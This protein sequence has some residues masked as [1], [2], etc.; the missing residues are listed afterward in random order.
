[1][2]IDQAG[3]PGLVQ[4]GLVLSQE[5]A[6]QVEAATTPGRRDRDLVL[7]D[8]QQ[9]VLDAVSEGHNVIVDA[10][11]GSGKAL[12]DQARVPTPGGWRRV[13]EIG[14]GDQLYNRH[15]DPVTVLGVYPQGL[16]QA[17]RVTLA[18]GRQVVCSGD[19]NWGVYRRSGRFQQ[20]ETLTTRQMVDSGL[21]P[22]L[23]G[24]SA[25]VSEFE[26]PTHAA[27]KR[28]AR[29][30]AVD[31]YVVGAFAGGGCGSEPGLS[32]SSQTP[33]VAQ[34][35]ARI[36]GL[37]TR[38]LLE[39]DRTWVFYRDDG[40]RS[41]GVLRDEVLQ[42]VPEICALPGARRL[43]E[44]YLLGS[45]EQRRALLQGLMDTRGTLTRTGTGYTACFST[46][47]AALAEQ[48]QDLLGSLGYVVSTTI[49]DGG[50][51]RL[52]W[53]DPGHD[54]A[55][56]AI[57]TIEDLGYRTEMTCF[58]VDDAESLFLTDDYVVTHNTATIQKLCAQASARGRRVL[59]LTYSRLLKVDAQAR[60]GGAR[61]QNYHGVVYP[62]LLAHGIEAGISESIRAFNANFD[63]IR[64]GF[65]A[66]DLLVIDEYQDINTEYARLIENI[67]SVNPGMQIVMVGDAD[68]KVQANTT[69]DAPAFARTFAGAQAKILP[70]TKTF[71]L[72]PELAGVLSKAWNKPIEG[73][74][75][76]QV[77]ELMDHEDAIELICATEPGDLLCL[78]KRNGAM[79]H[80]LNEVEKRAPA[81]Y[82]KDTVFASIKDGDNGVNPDETAAV[83]TTYDASKGM[84]RPVCVVFDYSEKTWDMRGGFAG[85]DH[86]VLRNVFLVAASRGKARVVFV[87][88]GAMKKMEEPRAGTAIGMIPVER[89]I[90]LPAKRIP[91][92]SR[93]FSPSSCFDFTY[94]ENVTACLDLITRRRL[95]T[96]TEKIIDI[97]RSDGFID[98]SPVIGV[99]QEALFFADFDAAATMRMMATVDESF[100]AE[101]LLSNLD[102]DPWNDSLVLAAVG[103]EQLRYYDQVTAEVASDEARALMDR[104]GEHLDRDA[105]AQVRL[106]L[107]GSAHGGR[108]GAS[109]PISFSGFADAMYR[110]QLFE[111]KFVSALSPEMFLQAALY[112]VMARVSGQD[113][114]QAV[115]WNT[116]TGERWAVDVEDAE[117][118]LH[119]VVRCVTKQ[120]YTRFSFEVLDQE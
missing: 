32:I 49:G 101:A 45:V 118:F 90:D 10:V 119:A 12:P 69:L 17:Y 6:E 91:R 106:S 8:E 14:V 41:G 53:A 116:R 82:N 3:G 46:V 84:E 105:P 37:G 73:M 28:P 100:H 114:H 22:G 102:G 1:M 76:E 81:R 88:S 67:R 25:P 13:G 31:P 36:L 92:Y 59:Y 72:G 48:V 27:V 104:L 71:R 86:V 43:P 63:R 9:A 58:A 42:A 75:T 79:P 109:S 94:A 54:R 108:Q 74:N 96:G 77:V 65:P 85:A 115:L 52:S 39:T 40:P 113:L 44:E 89:F 51:Q 98:L 4:G 61:V 26:I 103:T 2:G 16:E 24:S 66:Y 117:E 83:F 50:E 33:R 99:Y 47:S 95:D 34:K 110:D 15:G 112:L 78:G 60:V 80:A 93:P 29:A 38:R 97:E 7:S 62:Y 55:R 5:L 23:P 56:V 30:L 19:H 107:E 70:F 57:H 21:V 111:L 64:H 18:D 120:A 68:Q 11:C 20:L 35:I 87:R